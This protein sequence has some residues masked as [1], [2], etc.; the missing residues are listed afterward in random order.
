MT[1]AVRFALV[2]AGGVA[3]SYAQAF[4]NCDEVRVVAVAD[5]VPQAAQ[6]LA[7]RL[8]C[9]GFPSHESLVRHG[10]GFDAIVLCTPPD[11]HETLTTWF[12]QR[13]IA[14]LCEKPFTL[15]SSS[16][17][18]MAQAAAAGRS[19]LTMA[20]KF[21]FVADLVE[22]RRLLQAGVLGTP[23]V[24]ENVFAAQ[25]DMRHRW[26]SDPEISGGGVWI[27]NGSHAA[28]IMRF[29]LGP[30]TEVMLVE[31]PRTQGL[32]VEET[33]QFLGRNR[34]GVLA[35]SQLSWSLARDQDWF[36]SILGSEGCVQVGWKQSR[37]RT[38]TS[39]TWTVFGSGYNKVE[40]FQ[41]QLLNF[42]RAWRGQEELRITLDDAL[43]SV[44]VIEAGYQALREGCWV[45]VEE[46]R[47]ERA[48]A[49]DNGTPA[50]CPAKEASGLLEVGGL[51]C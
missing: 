25:T 42:A 24:V 44:A 33:V 21:R 30:L 4:A 22:A 7:S 34:E 12:L 13:G 10:P 5:V 43:A 23:L 41:A 35:L 19:L 14:V 6:S 48:P 39:P 46:P 8:G 11:S 9:P 17:Q 37:Y 26:N 2:G 3:R 50:R 45:R 29:L 32:A 20:S 1:E 51:P 15:N 28:D 31:A 40:A 36:V 16:A 49:A 27:D 18:R 47:P 38:H